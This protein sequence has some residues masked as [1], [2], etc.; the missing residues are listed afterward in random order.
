[1]RSWYSTPTWHY[2]LW[3]FSQLYR[4]IITRRRRYYQKN[5]ARVTHLPVPMVVVGNLTVGG[6]GKTPLIISLVNLLREKG[7]RPGVISRGYKGK[8]SHYP[9]QVF[10]DSKVLQT[11]DEPLLIAQRSGCP[12]V[13]DPNRVRAAKYLLEQTDCNV[14]VS[15]DG[16]QHYALGRDIEIA[17][18]DGK[19]RFGNNMLLP[20]G[21][22]RE[23]IG[24]LAQVDYIVANGHAEIGEHLMLIEQQEVYN[25][26][27]PEIK[28]SLKSLC[29]GCA[30][31]KS[32][33]ILT[34]IRKVEHTKEISK[35]TTIA[36]PK[37]WRD[38][39]QRK[40]KTV[41]I[42]GY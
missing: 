39:L 17:V 10:A 29:L 26:L 12:V 25:L 3:P 23:P 32:R 9:M 33:F 28:I 22:M 8:A 15:D 11:G 6:T 20:A 13:V 38:S 31:V 24:R 34:A 42:P 27:N 37:N 14:I 16:L 36:H 5:P 35:V 4:F 1:M 19:R 2:A 40:Q 30:G 7:Y 21:P 41:G 18:V